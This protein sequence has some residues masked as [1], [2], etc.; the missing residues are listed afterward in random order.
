MEIDSAKIV[1]FSPTGTTKTV[2]QGIVKGINPSSV[3]LIDITTPSGR[4]QSL[5]TTENELLVVAVPV[6]MGRVPALVVEWLKTIKSSKTPVVCVVV[7]GNRVYDDALLELKD[8]VETCGC[9]PVGCGAYI[10]EH[11][12]S[13]AETPIAEGRPNKDD[14]AHAEDFGRSISKKL[15]AVSFSSQLSDI[16]VPGVRPYGGVTT[17]WNVDFIA[18]N[19]LCIQCGVCAE[20]CPV[21]AIASQDYTLIDQ[22][23]CITCCAC[24]KNCPQSARAIKPSPV[25]DASIRL[26]KLFQEPKQPEVYL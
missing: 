15:E 5:Q 25:K 21:G 19:D 4:E 13:N 14:L 23:K 17:L 12:F 1:Y 22:E 16:E 6:Y 26:N 2:A 10:G 18:V 3:D 20:I 9:I 7:Y 8:I 11:S 24:I